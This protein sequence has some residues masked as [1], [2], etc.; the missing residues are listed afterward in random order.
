MAKGNPKGSINDER[1]G[2]APAG[3]GRTVTTGFGGKTHNVVV[4]DR[5]EPRSAKGAKSA[6]MK[7]G[8]Y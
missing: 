1:G 5:H 6:G 2:P 4:A 7:G 8:A 3:G